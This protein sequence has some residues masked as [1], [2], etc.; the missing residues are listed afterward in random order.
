MA[1]VS[2]SEG[3]ASSISKE[4]KQFPAGKVRTSELG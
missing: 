1:C 3:I 2:A 4:E